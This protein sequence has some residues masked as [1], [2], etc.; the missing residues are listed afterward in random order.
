[1]ILTITKEFFV[2]IA[3]GS[4][5]VEYRKDISYYHKKFRNPDLGPIRSIT[6]H[7]RKRVYLE[8]RVE[9]IRFIRRPKKLAKSK[10]ID[11]EKCFAIHIKSARVY[12]EK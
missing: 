6:F 11:T 8:C 5:T 3:D 4:K 12:T 1:M 2:K 10:F 9:K 7:Y